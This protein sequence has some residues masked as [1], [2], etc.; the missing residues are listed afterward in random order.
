ML[1]KKEEFVIE[2]LLLS[3][4]DTAKALSISERTLWTYTKNGEIPCV[5]LGDR[6]LYDP[7]D[8]RAWIELK[9]NK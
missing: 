3:A 5:R 7:Q 8:L 2:P 1:D 6:V 9:K 4:K